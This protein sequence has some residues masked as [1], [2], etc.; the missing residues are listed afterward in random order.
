[1]KMTNEKSDVEDV[2]IYRP[3][4]LLFACA[5]QTKNLQAGDQTGFRCTFQAVEHLLTYGIMEQKEQ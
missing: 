1:M 2:G 4:W 3:I 5:V